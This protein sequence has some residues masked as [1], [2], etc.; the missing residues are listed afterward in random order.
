LFVSICG[1]LPT[2]DIE[3]IWNTICPIVHFVQ[4]GE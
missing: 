2:C 4:K 3:L 1:R